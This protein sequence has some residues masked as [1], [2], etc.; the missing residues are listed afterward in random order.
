[1]CGNPYIAI[2]RVVL[3]VERT[4]LSFEFDAQNEADV[5]RP[6]DVFG[7]PPPREGWFSDGVGVEV[8]PSQTGR[9]S[10]CLIE[11][12]SQPSRLTS[13]DVLRVDIADIRKLPLTNKNYKF[14]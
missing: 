12:P 13:V 1:M 4:K 14:E 6:I 5:A 10:M 9:Q 7:R 2:L 8:E 3:G 11:N